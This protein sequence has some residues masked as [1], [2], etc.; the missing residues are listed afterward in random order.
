MMVKFP[1]QKILVSFSGG[2]TSAYMINWLLKNKPDYEYK[3]VFANTGEE[4]E[5]TLLFVKQCAEFF[6]III[7]WVE[8]CDVNGYK[9]VNFETAY[10][11]HDVNEISNRWKNHPF[12]KYI[13]RFGI[14]NLQDISCT[15]ELKEYPINRYM[16][17]NGWK[18]SMYDKAIG[19][20]ADELD[21]V[22]KYYYPLL[23]IN[24][25]KEMVN[26]FWAKMPFR[27]NLKGW[28]GNC[29][30]CWKK[31][32]RKLITIARYYPE[33]FAFFKIMEDEYGNKISNSRKNNPNVIL[34]I[35]FFRGNK[36]VEDI[37]EMSKDL[38]IQDAVDDTKNINYQISIW[39][40]GTELDIMNGCVES[41][42]AFN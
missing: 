35:R 16:S 27:L 38:S 5:E 42:N 32:I 31:S 40:D 19:I 7:H 3:F 12:R 41:C 2:E 11:S 37:F 9:E 29:K 10:R 15:R 34:P 39:H 33:R 18:R 26:A 13:N 4:N 20:R 24:A 17:A 28:E 1:K 23:K 8:Y 25:T 22:G 30:V 36:S 14:P 6:G 21:R